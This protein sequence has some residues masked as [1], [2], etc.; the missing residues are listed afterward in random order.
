MKVH[1]YWWGRG[2]AIILL[3]HQIWEESRR[4]PSS[5]MVK[6]RTWMFLSYW[7]S[8]WEWY[9]Y[10]ISLSI[11][12]ITCLKPG[13]I[14]RTGGF[15]VRGLQ[16]KCSIFGL[17]YIFMDKGKSMFKCRSQTQLSILDLIKKDLLFLR[18][19]T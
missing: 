10:N 2:S 6:W 4:R 12:R 19:R 14:N 9:I 17:Y 15:E 13:E 8:F 7:P 1:W 3:F 18:W 16:W 11:T 5:S